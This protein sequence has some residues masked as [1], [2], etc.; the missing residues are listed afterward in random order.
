[1]RRLTE[2]VV[3]TRPIL[4][5]ILAAPTNATVIAYETGGGTTIRSVDL[6]L[7]TGTTGWLST[8]RSGSAG[9]FRGY[10]YLHME[11]VTNWVRHH[12]EK[13]SHFAII[14]ASELLNL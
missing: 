3:V 10:D 8:G 6:L 14:E 12:E 1:M 2:E 9:G 5:Q 4:G 13:G 11:E 7:R